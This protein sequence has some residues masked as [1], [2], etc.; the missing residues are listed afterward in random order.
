MENGTRR[1]SRIA[2]AST[3]PVV[4]SFVDHHEN[5]P[6]LVS[7]Q[8]QTLA[9]LSATRP[10]ESRP[11]NMNSSQFPPRNAT[12]RVCAPRPNGVGFLSTIAIVNPRRSRARA[13]PRAELF[14]RRLFLALDGGL[15]AQEHEADGEADEGDGEAGDGNLG[16]LGAD[17]GN[18]GDGERGG[19][20]G[21]AASLGGLH[22]G[23]RELGVDG[24]E[25]EK[26]RRG[27][28]VSPP[29]EDLMC[30]D[31]RAQ[32]GR[33]RKTDK[34]GLLVWV[35]WAGWR[36]THTREVRAGLEAWT[37]RAELM[38]G[39]GKERSGS[40]SGSRARWTIAR[41]VRTDSSARQAPPVEWRT[42]RRCDESRRTA[43]A[44]RRARRT[45]RASARAVRYG[46]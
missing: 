8:R 29:R 35:C 23:G 37:A 2:L 25:M 36:G 7:S 22:R 20:G 10:K 14:A 44:A 31:A 28:S 34:G 17:G 11:A 43:R 30:G 40:A 32:G 26:R 15:H 19:G 4:R 21:H 42:F 18:L 27:G 3:P 13:C 45:R 24:A 41:V 5:V 9:K 33:P 39:G 1:A 38:M 12:R 6:S 16:N 46:C